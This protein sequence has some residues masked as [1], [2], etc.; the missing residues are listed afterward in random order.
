MKKKKKVPELESP[1]ESPRADKDQINKDQKLD[2]RGI[3]LIVS[4]NR[5]FMWVGNHVCKMAKSSY[6]L[7]TEAYIKKLQKFEKAPQEVMEVGQGEEPPSFW[8]AFGLLG[9]PQEPVGMNPK[10]TLWFASFDEDSRMRSAR[11]HKSRFA[12]AEREELKDKPAMFVYPFYQEPLFVLDMDDLKE[13]GLAV[14]CDRAKKMCYI[15]E[16]SLFKPVEEPN[17]PDVP[18]FLTLVLQSFFEVEDTK[19]IIKNWQ[20]AGEETEAFDEYFK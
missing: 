6:M 16:G 8:A 9:G 18:Q 4:P 15:W 17:V 19:D 12:Y 1:A 10:W 20:K 13:E 3:F 7:A 2:P 11:S 14:L 5:M